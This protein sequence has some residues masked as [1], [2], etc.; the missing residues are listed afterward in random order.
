MANTTTISRNWKA[1][2]GYAATA[3]LF[4]AGAVALFLGSSNTFIFAVSIALALIGLILV[5]MAVA[6]SAD[7]RCPGCGA[8]LDSLSMRDNDGVLCPACHSFLEGKDGKLWATDP[9]RIAETPLFG[10]ALPASFDWPAGC[11]VCGEPAT[12][13]DPIHLKL[14]EKDS[15][16]TMLAVSAVTGGAVRSVI[17]AGSTL[18]IDVPHCAAHTGGAA[19]S[20]D[21]GKTIRI[22]FKSYPYLRQFCERNAVQPQ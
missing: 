21:D 6:G 9:N 5:F 7:A 20:S 18:T 22:R 2:I 8:L 13:K 15:A 3:L 12:C 1:T 19:L 10:A 4:G 16:S 14:Y 11:C 17:H